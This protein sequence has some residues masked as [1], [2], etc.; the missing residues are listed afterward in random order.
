V[1]EAWVTVDGRETGRIGPGLLIL[2]GVRSTDTAAERDWL[3]DKCLNLRIFEDDAGKFNRS[4]LDVRGDL[5]VV[6]QFT[7]YGDARQ[8]RRPSFTDAAAPALAEPMYEAFIV[9]LRQSGL[10]VE[11]GVF[12]A[13]MDVF[14]HNS[15]PVTLML[16]REA[17]NQEVT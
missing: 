7:L 4:V 17:S 10:R 12:G 8:G 15:G 11:T 6:S 2:L 16:E 5:L 3:A 1:A 13:R 9:A 14:L